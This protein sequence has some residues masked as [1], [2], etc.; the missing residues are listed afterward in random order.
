MPDDRPVIRRASFAAAL[1][2]LAADRPRIGGG[3]GPI[4]LRI[5]ARSTHRLGPQEAGDVQATGRA[6]AFL[7]GLLYAATERA[8]RHGLM[9]PLRSAPAGLPYVRLTLEELGADEPVERPDREAELVAML[10][11]LEW[12]DLTDGGGDICPVC[13]RFKPRDDGW[14]NTGHTPDCELAAL[15]GVPT[16]A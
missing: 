9:P 12:L 4:E 8:K 11:R 13:K 6:F 7:S 3:E 1:E 15:I 16:T 14:A 10:R 2:N 5:R